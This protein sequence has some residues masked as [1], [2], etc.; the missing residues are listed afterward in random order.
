MSA[1]N[2]LRPILRYLPEIPKAR[3]P[4]SFREKAA[5]TIVVL[6]IYIVFTQ[7]PLY[8]LSSVSQSVQTPALFSIIFAT[9]FGTLAQ[10]GV[11]P[12]VTA[13]LIMQ[14]LVG[15]KIINL[16]L[17]DK[18]QRALFTGTQKFLAIIF[19]ILEASV[20]VSS[21][22][23]PAG[24]L[25]NAILIVLQLL[26]V[27][28]LIIL[29]DEILQKGWGF[30]SAVSLFILAGITLQISVELF[31]PAFANGSYAGILPEAI[32][33]LSG[34]GS[35]SDFLFGNP[36]LARSSSLIGLIAMIITLIVVVYLQ[37]VKIEI[38]VTYPKYGGVRAKI[39]LQLIYVS[40][41]PVILAGALAA[42][43]QFFSQIAWNNYNRAN[44]DPL[45]N[46]IAQFNVINNQAVPSGG[47]IYYLTAPR[48][49]N[50]AIH[51]PLH[52]L[53][54]I[55]IFC[56][57]CVLFALAWVETSGM[58]A[59][60]QAKRLVRSG[61]QVPGFRNSE[62]VLATLLKRYTK[63]LTWFSGL[64]VGLIASVSDTVGIIGTGIGILLSVGIVYQ[65]YMI[66]A[67][68]RIEEEF[69]SIARLLEVT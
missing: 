14:L 55:I 44:S 18:S 53:I 1:L 16:D 6:T 19:T 45:W 12:I 67:R 38:P 26:G 33:V 48:G 7:I 61:I 29:F 21:G 54:Y 3:R 59:E 25:G 64:L 49:L 27:G 35:M 52:A 68:E 63:T 60:E 57:L 28:I 65:F 11:G 66:L 34:G 62:V 37:Q 40:N 20:F 24:S 13:G 39:P 36:N 15:S 17:T 2:S 51:D 56:L 31:S 43:L 50:A 22:L 23:L 4:V 8:P 58:S 42:N 47:L 69:P 5:W 10:L 30:G 46:A 9:R 41:V 32:Y